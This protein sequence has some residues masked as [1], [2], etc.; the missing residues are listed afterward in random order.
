MVSL[1]GSLAFQPLTL[2]NSSLRWALLIMS[3]QRLA[4]TLIKLSSHD[5]KVVH[6]AEHI[7]AIFKYFRCVSVNE[8][9]SGL[10]LEIR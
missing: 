2:P 8:T 7:S 1:F 6:V 4:Q 10:V 5:L 9:S 3:Q